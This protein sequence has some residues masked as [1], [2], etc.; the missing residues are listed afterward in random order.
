MSRAFGL[1]A[2]VASVGLSSALMAQGATNGTTAPESAPQVTVRA[3][4]A[5]TTLADWPGLALSVSKDAYVTVFAVTRT[6]GSALP[7]QIL[8]PARPNQAG[9]VKGGKTVTP[10]LLLGD[11]AM[12]LLS[13]GESP[14]IVAFASS[15]KPE[16]AA[17]KAG[18]R[19]GSDL[20]MD[21][22][23]GTDQ[24]MVEILAKTIYAPGV[25]FDA[26]VSAPSTITPLARVIG[27]VGFDI[28]QNM[29]SLFVGPFTF[30]NQPV[31]V[32]RFGQ[33]IGGQIIE[34][35]D[36]VIM[37]ADFFQNSGMV[38]QALLNGFPFT[39]KGGARASI[40]RAVGGDGYRLTYWPQENKP[41]TADQKKAAQAGASTPTTTPPVR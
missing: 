15:V 20:L 10:R 16:L 24:Q 38:P 7:I 13:Y 27:G 14:L 6:N 8:S 40:T 12:H 4:T 32:T 26:V 5:V 28:Q 25:L 36:P 19:W 29:P 41:P 17:F 30:G 31:T 9:R 22:L 11:E 34:M 35:V 23:A 2:T 33:S 21:T 1:L 18:A 39:L 37:T 3:V